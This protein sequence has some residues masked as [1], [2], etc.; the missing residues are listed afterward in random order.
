ML[1][2][3]EELFCEYVNF[4]M[5]LSSVNVAVY[6]VVCDVFFTARCYAE[7][8]HATAWRLYVCPTVR[9]VQVP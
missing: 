8:G 9:D 1:L 4:C 7:H 5:S 6:S 3:A 2:S